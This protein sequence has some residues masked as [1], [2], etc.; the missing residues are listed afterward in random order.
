[1]AKIRRILIS[2]ATGL[3]GG[4]CLWRWQQ[5]L[6]YELA[7]IVRQPEELPAQAWPGVKVIYGDLAKPESLCDALNEVQPDLVVHCAA[8]TNVDKC[9]HEPERCKT[10]NTSASGILAAAAK[11]NGSALVYISTDAV[12]AKGPGPHD[13]KNAGGDL[14]VYAASKLEAESSV[15]KAHVGALVLRTCMIGWNQNPG[16]SS[17]AEWIVATLSEGKQLPGFADVRFSPLFTG[18]LAKLMLSAAQA[19]LA[20]VYNLG[21]SDGLS[22][23]QTALLFAQGLGLEQDMV[24]PVSQKQADLAVPRPEDPVMESDRFYNALGEEAPTVA[25]EVEAMLAME[26]NG[27]LQNFRR[28]G[29]YA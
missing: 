13:E 5:A 16:L 8:L 7:V 2:G 10:L 27:E 23:Y 28:F 21:S 24:K 26:A 17:L 22:K 25:Q 4:M 3:L 12:Y 18:T 1:M 6:K 29:G 19:G 15:M 9:Q 20:G 11:K 14:S